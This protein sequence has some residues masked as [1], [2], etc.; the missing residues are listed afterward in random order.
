MAEEVILRAVESIARAYRFIVE[1]MGIEI[2]R[3]YLERVL[4][5]VSHIAIHEL[6][7]A[8]IHVVYPEIDELYRESEVL[9]ECVDEVGGRI[10]EIYVSRGV[11]APTHSFEEHV[12]ELEHYS[13]LR[14]LGIRARDLEALYEEASRLIESK[15]LRKAV[16]LVVAKCRSLVEL[17]RRE[18]A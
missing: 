15:D 7:H 1:S 5:E 16:E 2:P 18:G 6:A 9:G 11:G 3:S 4:G 17:S 10:L 12:Y 13:N 14:G 8:V